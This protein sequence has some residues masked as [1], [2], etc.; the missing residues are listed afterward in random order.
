MSDPFT[1]TVPGTDQRLVVDGDRLRAGDRVF[2]RA[3]E[4]IWDLVD[5]TSRPAI[6]R[7]ADDYAAVRDAEGRHFDADEIRRLPDTAADHPHA[8]MW[9]QRRASWERLAALIPDGSGRTALDLGAGNGWLA[10]R[11]AERGWRAAAIDVTVDGPD[12]LRAARAHGDD[13]LLVR[14]DMQR[15]PF[16]SSSVDLVV[17]NASLHYAHDA[18]ATLREC[19]RVLTPAGRLAVLDSP[20]FADPDAGTRMVA[21]FAADTRNR[22]GVAAAEHQGP[23]FLTW[24]ELAPFDFERHDLDRPLANRFHR[25]RGARRAGR[26]TAQRPVLTTRP[27]APGVLT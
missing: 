2:E 15:L 20:V 25:W 17:C 9:S 5:P 8:A 27:A 11:L 12:G 10:A 19:R 23:G 24:A 4:G 26:E 13:L 6:D 18:G 7:F 21:E 1:L 16:A 22:L 3:A 14:A